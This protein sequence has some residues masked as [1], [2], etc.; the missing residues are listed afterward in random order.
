MAAVKAWQIISREETQHLVMSMGSRLQSLTAKDLHPREVETIDAR[1]TAPQKAT[2]DMFGS[3]TQLAQKG[4]LSIAVPGE[5][6]GY[7]LAHRRHGRL[8]WRELFQPSIQLA[9]EGIRVSKGLAEAMQ[10]NKEDI[11]ANE[12]LW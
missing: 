2:R 6:R 3:D 11:E 5:L 7:E 8:P 10:K 4:G 9:R 12:T 1:E